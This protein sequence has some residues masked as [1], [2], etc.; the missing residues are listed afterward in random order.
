MFLLMACGCS[1]L[2][3]EDFAVYDRSEKLNRLSFKLSDDVD[4]V[5]LSPVARG[6]QSIAP[7]WLEHG[8]ANV[9][10]NLRTIS[11]SINGFLQGKPKAGATDLA[12][13]I[14][15]ST[16]GIVGFFDPASRIGLEYQ[17]ED[18]GQT[19]A[20]WGWKK[21]RY[22]YVPML[23]PTTIRDLP[24]ML[25]NGYLPQLLIGSDYHW[26]IGLVDVVSARA[27]VLTATNVRDASAL[28][29]YAF[30][31]D[32]YIQRQK[33]LVYDGDLP[34][35]DLFDDFVDDFVDDELDEPEG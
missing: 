12:R 16:F 5:V 14:V 13:I 7:D 29:R 27:G 33:Y 4:R 9:F 15:N 6:Y 8:V 32:A 28:D 21:S 31:R 20:V 35:E 23:G 2:S 18:L 25:V 24:S 22:V 34:Y 30:T 1:T 26:S 19:F 17:Q 11:S 10:R 3:G